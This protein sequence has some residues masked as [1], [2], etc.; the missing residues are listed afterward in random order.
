MEAPSRRQQDLNKQSGWPGIP[1]AFAD[2]LWPRETSSTPQQKGRAAPAKSEVTNFGPAAGLALTTTAS[3]TQPLPA[4]LPTP[5]AHRLNSQ[6]HGKHLPRWQ[7]S[8]P[9]FF[10]FCD[11]LGVLSRARE[12]RTSRG[13]DRGRV[14]GALVD[15]RTWGEYR[16]GRGGDLS[17]SRYHSKGGASSGF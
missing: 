11:S 8:Q 1:G 12:R 7:V 13:K 14:R 15:W 3:A 16:R 9:T 4:L 6:L 17:H 10:R 2:S 5:N